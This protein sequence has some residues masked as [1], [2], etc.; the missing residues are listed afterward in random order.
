MSWIYQA[1]LNRKEAKEADSWQ[2]TARELESNVRSLKKQIAEAHGEH[3]GHFEV[4]REIVQELRGL[5]PRR[6]SLP[7]ADTQRHSH[8]LQ[9]RNEAADRM[10]KRLEQQGALETPMAPTQRRPRP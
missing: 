4:A 6:L 5:K 7:D 2:S 1:L 3:R 8:F 9:A 10:S